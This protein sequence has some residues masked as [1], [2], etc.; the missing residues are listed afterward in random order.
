MSTS[1][2]FKLIPSK[3]KG[4]EGVICVQLIHNRKIKLFRTRFRLFPTEWDNKDESIIFGNSAIERQIQLQTVETGMEAEMKQ[5][6][7][8]INLLERKS[9]YSV[10][11]LLTLYTNNS[12]NGYFF[13]FIDYMI[14][15]LKEE[16]R[17]KTAAILLTAKTSFNR[18]HTGQDIL[19]DKIDNDLMQKYETWLKTSGVMKNTIS[20]Y[21][22][23]LRSAYNQAVKRGLTQQRN[24]FANIFTRIDKT[25]KRAVNE[26]VIIRLHNLDLKE[27]PELALARDLFMFSFYMRGISFVDMINLRKNNVKNGY[28][29]YSRSKTKQMLAI[30]IEPCMEEI[31]SRYELQVIEDYLLPIYSI[32]N[33][34]NSSQLRKHNKRLKRISEILGLEKSLS[35]YVSRHTWASLAFRKGIPVEVISE[36]MGHENESTTRI[37]LASLGQSVVDKANAEIIKSFS[38]SDYYKAVNLKMMIFKTL[39]FS[40]IQ[41]HF[42]LLNILLN[43]L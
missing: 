31:V 30:K 21:M 17:Q 33:R 42:E 28:I 23:A 34:D 32:Q 29:T 9:D 43:K 38:N 24:P 18:F 8:L 13:T 35:S 36:S 20:C 25:T 37:Y 11:E 3:V 40:K 10:E 19:L 5:I 7:E 6:T 14:K 2:K 12:F 4:K 1:I 15:H 22:R 16:N 41:C 39:F 26:D 27:Y